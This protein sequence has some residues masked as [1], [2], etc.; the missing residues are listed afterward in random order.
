MEILSQRD[1]RWKSIVLGKSNTKIGGYGCTITCVAML[2]GLTPDVVNARLNEVGGYAAPDNAPTQKNLINW[3]KVNAAIPELQFQSRVRSMD[4]DAVNG[5]VN[6]FGACLVEVDFDGARGNLRHWVLWVGGGRMY[7]PWTG[8][9]ED[10]GKYEPIGFA[11]IAKEPEMSERQ[12]QILSRIGDENNF[13]LDG[14]P[15]TPTQLLTLS[16]EEVDVFI[17]AQSQRDALYASLKD[18]EQ[19]RIKAENAETAAKDQL[20]T[21]KTELTA[22]RQKEAEVVGKLSVIQQQIDTLTRKQEISDANYKTLQDKYQTDMANKDEQTNAALKACQSHAQ[23]YE[24]RLEAAQ[25]AFALHLSQK[26]QEIKDLRA[27]IM[28]E[29]TPGDLWSAFW[30]KIM[31]IK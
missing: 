16:R 3:Y 30:R 7:D 28:G 8:T 22:S 6:N 17:V 27:A 1:P 19:A 31:R 9:E 26:D 10:L 23:E 21:T 14:D 18:Q 15:I 24:D 25:Q 4:Y 11:I 29:Q 13:F 2:A 12:K 5:A 20:A